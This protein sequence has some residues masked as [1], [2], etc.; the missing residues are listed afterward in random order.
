MFR[1]KYFDRVRQ[2]QQR[3]TPLDTLPPFD[4]QRLRTGRFGAVLRSLLP[5]DPRWVFSA[6]RR[7]LPVLRL[8]G[9]TVLTRNDDIREVLERQDAFETPFGLEMAEMAGGTN[10]ILGMQDGPGYRC[11]K[12][13]VLS[14]FP[15]AEVEARVREIARRHSE[16]IMR[17]A[18]PGVNVVEQLLKT[19]PV[20]ICRDYCGLTIDDERQFADW[21]IALSTLFFAD[22]FGNSTKRDLAL[23][24]A[25]HMR[26][27]IER[28]IEIVAA[29]EHPA[30]TPLARLVAMRNADPERVTVAHIRSIMMGMVVGFVPTNLLAAGKALDTALTMPDAQAAVEAAVASDDQGALD[31]AILEIMRFNPALSMQMRYVPRN[32]VVAAGTPRERTLPAGST[33]FCLMPSAMLDPDAIQ[34]P[35]DFRPGRPAKDYLVFGHGIHWC[36]GSA[37]ARVQIGECFRALF[38]RPGLRRVAGKAG[39][40]QTIGVFPESLCVDFDLLPQSRVTDHAF[41]TVAVPVVSGADV[42]A[43]RHH[44]AQLGNPPG[45]DVRAAFDETGIVHFASL[46]VIGRADPAEE[47][48]DDLY[49]VVLELTADGTK[50]AALAAVAN[51]AEAFLRPIFRN[52]CG[53]KDDESLGAFL[54]RHAIDVAPGFHSP[55]GLCFSGVPGHS[56]ARIRAEAALADK[57]A[58]LNEEVVSDGPLTAA[59]KLGRARSRLA[60]DP[61][62]QWAFQPAPERLSGPEHSPWAAVWALARDPTL[63]AGLVIAALALSVPFHLALFRDAAT[64]P[65]SLGLLLLAALL[66]GVA[67]LVALLLA[68]FWLG[69]KALNAKE[70][71]DRV[72]SELISEERFA[73]IAARENFWAHNHLAAVSQ[74]KGGWLRH[75][76]LRTAFFA[77]SLFGR[78]VFAPG[79]LADI[80][81]IHFARWAMLPGTG[82]LL[83]FSNYGGSW[84]SYLEDFIVKAHAGLT[85][86]WSNTA[87]FPRTVDLFRQGAT[88]GVR[89]K[90]WARAQQIPT[91][92]WYSA[93]PRMTT[94]HIRANARLR[95]ALARNDAAEW[96]ACLGAEEAVSS[97]IETG[98]VQSI[99]FGG[100]GALQEA[101]MLAVAI[102]ETVSR[103]G[104][105]AW[106]DHLVS[107]LS[108]GDTAPQE[109][110]MIAAFSASG[111]SRLGFDNPGAWA[112]LPLAF[113]RGM[114]CED[115]SRILGDIGRNAPANWEWG[116]GDAAPD[117]VL[118][119]YARDRERLR[120]DLAS[121]VRATR[122][123]GLNI[124]YRLPLTIE[125]DKQG[126]A[127]EHFGYRDNI[128]QPVVEG[129][130]RGRRPVDP[131][132]RLAAGEFLLGYADETGRL[133]PGIAVREGVGRRLLPDM[134]DN[135]GWADFGRNGSFLVVRQMEQHVDAFETYCEREAKR[136]AGTA[137]GAPDL[138]KDWIGAKMMG[139]WKDG[140][141]LVRNGA[142]DPRREPD[143]HFSYAAEDPN[144]LYCPFGA[145]VRRSNPRDSLGS[146][147]EVQTRLSKRH[148]ILRIGRT[149]RRS[150]GRG[151]AEERGMLFM[152]LNAEIERQFEFVQ[153]SWVMRRTFQS[154]TDEGDPFVGNPQGNGS[155]TIP[156]RTGPI[157]LRELDS[158]VTLRGGGYFFMPGRG[159]LNYLLSRLSG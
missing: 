117:A 123:A 44:V 16:E 8:G 100:M 43:L 154:L 68:A 56:V 19:V 37:L 119:C 113:R 93:Y 104:R 97:P 95:Q 40:L 31:A 10:F 114:A 27:A 136:L 33:I 149:Y 26:Q 105:R 5:D 42:A 147:R 106:L 81:S 30:D 130:P 12:S 86:V 72:E 135:P 133:P 69:R 128:S 82:K 76:T 92:F 126:K 74:M 60:D 155:F 107:R 94:G 88:D 49:H 73:E 84:E 70:R 67:A 17:S 65:F 146:N 51:C 4:L 34:D 132:H 131:Q 139:R 158:F 45:E 85:G 129:T 3:K 122:K 102:P 29:A 58:R 111:L 148:R 38:A 142:M 35:D 75:L 53:L 87:G 78:N 71:A 47:R 156:D 7:W 121:L 28:S 83:F 151:Q 14:A 11:M 15:P 90:H 57:L 134:P 36:I 141:S 46:S 124:L 115:Q 1:T 21:A 91:L 79:R 143:N 157:L 99:F 9:I 140:G 23:V 66:L 20:R 59:R 22:P 25:H 120:T 125:R 98:E 145:H 54:L 6:L 24:A 18:M 103:A 116:Q 48:P 96:C 50:A 109:R 63:I 64:G 62:W 80:G 159:A 144:G 108:F 110:A 61:D 89:F 152:C 77:I 2:A 52:G 150:A 32:A 138:D 39:R 101:E 153:Q 13:T 127:I 41:V 118:V 55:A 137:G 112:A